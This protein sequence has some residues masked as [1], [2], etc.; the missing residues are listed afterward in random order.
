MNVWNR[1]RP[2]VWNRATLLFLLLALVALPAL[3]SGPPVEEGSF[4][5]SELVE[6]KRLEPT[7]RLDL[8]YA[9]PHNFMKRVLYPEA[10]AFLQRPA[11]LALAEVNRK[12]RPRG[13][14][15]SVLDAYRPWR[16]TR[17]MWEQA[18]EN[19]RR[20]GY[21]ADPQKGSRHNRG[22]AVDV[23]LYDLQTGRY[24]DMPGAYDEFTERAHAD[25]AGGTTRQR[26]N[27]DLLI[28]AMKAEGFE[29]LDVEWWHFDFRDWREYPILDLD[30][31]EVPE[32]PLP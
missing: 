31:C 10:R 4:R 14:G 20:I 25:F 24:L 22:C 13:L 30:F 26:A 2:V 1:L 23:S 12:L 7:L 32:I 17:Q 21:V 29:V 8:R 5:E 11:A 19:W 6:L 3:A 27:R 28:A 18:P 15:V 16:V 9:T